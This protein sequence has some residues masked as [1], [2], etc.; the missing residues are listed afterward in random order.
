MNMGF[1]PTSIRPSIIPAGVRPR[2]DGSANITGGTHCHSMVTQTRSQGFTQEWISA[3]FS[4]HEIFAAYAAAVA[5]TGG[6]Y[7]IADSHRGN[8][9]ARVAQ[10]PR[11]RSN[12]ASAEPTWTVGASVSDWS[13]RMH[14]AK[15]SARLD[16]AY[17]FA[18]DVGVVRVFLCFAPRDYLHHA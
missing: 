14:A 18:A 16:V 4:R 11:R 10:Y 1:M 3:G 2:S 6:I 15:D 7:R 9:G 8:C 12:R 13:T 17:A 5:Q